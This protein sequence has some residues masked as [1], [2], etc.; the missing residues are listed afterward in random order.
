[1]YGW[2]EVSGNEVVQVV[3]KEAEAGLKKYPVEALSE[4][5]IKYGGCPESEG[6]HGLVIEA[7]LPLEA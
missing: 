4:Q 2:G 3:V 5:I 1:L 6:E 7:P